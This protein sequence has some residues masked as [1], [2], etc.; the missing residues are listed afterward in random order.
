MGSISTFKLFGSKNFLSGPNSPEVGGV[1]AF[2]R[3]VG[4]PTDFDPPEKI[5]INYG[6]TT[7]NDLRY[8]LYGRG[9]AGNIFVETVILNSSSVT[10]VNSFQTFF[11]IQK[12][13]YVPTLTDYKPIISDGHKIDSDDDGH[14]DTYSEGGIIDPS[15]DDTIRIVAGGSEIGTLESADQNDVP[16]NAQNPTSL[17]GEETVALLKPFFQ[18]Q[19]FPGYE[20][21]DKIFIVNAHK[22]VFLNNAAT[23]IDFD[24]DGTDVDLGFR[25]GVSPTLNDVESVTDYF[26]ERPDLDFYEPG[27]VVNIVHNGMNVLPSLYSAGVWFEA[28]PNDTHYKEFDIFLRLLGKTGTTAVSD[29]AEVPDEPNDEVGYAVVGIDDVAEP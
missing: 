1:V 20:F 22:T 29:E 27:E 16:N 8:R 5:T 19:V 21:Y 23:Q 3:K 15:L 12:L 7:S 18:V 4:Q 24:V 17:T 28:S 11:G 2:Y 9:I 14:L 10:T 13:V 6:G 26:N 25:F